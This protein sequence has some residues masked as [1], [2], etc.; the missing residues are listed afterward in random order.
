MISENLLHYYIN[1]VGAQSVQ[2]AGEAAQPR[3]RPESVIAPPT[4]SKPVAAA[5]TSDFY[6][7]QFPNSLPG[8]D[9]AVQ[10]DSQQLAGAV[11]AAG[12]SHHHTRTQGWDGPLSASSSQSDVSQPPEPTDLRLLAFTRD[13]YDRSLANYLQLLI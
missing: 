1:Q 11:A 6:A 2:G 13:R 8:G 12:E 7:S 10:Y 3:Y 4:V 5:T 9:R